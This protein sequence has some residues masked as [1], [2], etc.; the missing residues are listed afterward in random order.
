MVLVVSSAALAGDISIFFGNDKYSFG[1]SRNDDDNLSF[2]HGAEVEWDGWKGSAE[3]SGYTNR[4]WK[5]GWSTV[6]ST[7]EDNDSSHFY[8]GR[9]DSLSLC[10]GYALSLD[11]SPFSF[12][13]VPEAGIILTGNLGQGWVQNTF[14]TLSCVRVVDLDYDYASVRIHPVMG[15]DGK[16]SY[17]PLSFL[18]FS[19]GG[20]LRY[21]IGFSFDS[22]CFL[23][24]SA[25]KNGEEII[26]VLSGMRI[27]RDFSSSRTMQLFNEYV[28]GPYAGLEFD[29]GFFSALYMAELENRHGCGILAFHPLVL[30]ETSHWQESDIL[31]T[32]GFS[33]LIGIM[34]QEQN[35][36][37]PLSSAFSLVFG[38]TYIAGY[39]I[40]WER[41]S[42]YDPETEGRV[43]QDYAINSAGISCS[44]PLLSGWMRPYV[45][46]SFGCMKWEVTQMRNMIRD[47]FVPSSPYVG[48]GA[49]YS[50]AA[51]LEIGIRIM[52]EGFLTFSDVS[53]SVV[54][55]AGISYVTGDFVSSYRNVSEGRGDE[56]KSPMD[57]FIFHWGILLSFGIDL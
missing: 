47:S 56:E 18:S 2:F 49:D 8:S 1:L 3:F 9:L 14:H 4:G 32:T 55:A 22:E 7:I 53:L 21:E 27:R 35:I 37:I 29:F 20:S 5:R 36:E 26:S 57:N 39:P 11:L 46:L 17:S 43:R 51:D 12:R 19:L 45:S 16:V 44:F 40:S 33:H 42:T 48:D 52:S 50:F 23:S 54:P 15:F 25:V 10:T 30:F 34:F 28:N 41:E 6:D 38:T 13:L 24:L 31:F